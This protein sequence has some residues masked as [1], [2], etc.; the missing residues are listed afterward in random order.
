MKKGNIYII[1]IPTYILTEETNKMTETKCKRCGHEWD[2]TGN[3][4]WYTS[5]PKCRTSIK[6]KRD[7]KK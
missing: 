4:E 5:C 6:V 2:Y 1:I 7:D 3:S